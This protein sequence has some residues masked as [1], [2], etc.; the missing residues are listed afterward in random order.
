MSC[1]DPIAD[2]LTIIRNGLEA[3]KA[4]VSFPYSKIKEGLVQ[5]L[6]DEGYLSRVDVLDTKP[7]KTIKVALKYAANGERVIHAL[8]RISTPGRR[9]Y[10]GSK[11]LRPVV[12][13]FGVAIVSTSKG[14]LADR[15][16]REQR[17]GGE[18]LC[19]VV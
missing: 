5:V 18:V 19:E 10:R 2:A 7:A 4:Q 1:S 6:K 3:G 14:I 16:C 8:N 17:I 9:V 15:T 12:N 13:G 11:E